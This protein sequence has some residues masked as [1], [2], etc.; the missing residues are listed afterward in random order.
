MAEKPFEWNGRPYSVTE[1]GR[2]LCG[3]SGREIKQEMDRRY[4]R[5]CLAVD[6][7]KSTVSVHT[8]VARAFHGPRPEGMVVRH[9]DGDSRNNRADNLAYG[10]HRQNEDDKRLHGTK[11]MGEDLTNAKLN[12]QSVRAMRVLAGLVPQEIMAAALG[13]SK[14]TLSA[15]ARGESWAHV[16]GSM[17]LDCALRLIFSRY[18]PAPPTAL[19]KADEFGRSA[20]FANY[21]GQAK[22][23]TP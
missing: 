11:L 4:R 23:Q 18:R 9:L 7:M 6:G 20:H 22:D 12:D 3:R 16:D 8:I 21:Q 13:V 10:T 1:D 5:V 2:L 19:L 17:P 14:A 15:A